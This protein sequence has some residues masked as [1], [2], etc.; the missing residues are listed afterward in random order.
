M[1]DYD[2]LFENLPPSAEEQLKTMVEQHE[3]TMCRM[4]DEMERSMNS[5]AQQFESM[6]TDFAKRNKP[7]KREVIS[8][9]DKPIAIWQEKE[10][11]KFLVMNEA[12]ALAQASLLDKLAALLPELQKIV[13]SSSN[14][15][16]IN[17]LMRR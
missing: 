2:K 5:A 17:Q 3:E 10:G 4:R 12:A 6:A 8:N 13:A 15:P 16:N 14:L 1:T 11:K 9:G 7:E